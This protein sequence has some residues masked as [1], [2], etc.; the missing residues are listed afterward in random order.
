MIS[1]EAWQ[2]GLVF[3]SEGMGTLR[4]SSRHP[5]IFLGLPRRGG[6]EGRAALR[7]KGL[8]ACS[9][10]GIGE[11][12]TVLRFASPWKM[13]FE[14]ADGILRI[15]FQSSGNPAPGAEPAFRIRFDAPAW[16]HVYGLGPSS[17]FDSAGRK[18]NIGPSR[19]EGSA[20][21][22]PVAF[23]RRGS[24]LAI[25][26]GGELSL[27]FSR[28]HTEIRS[29]SL[30]SELAI[31]EVSTPY[32]G[33]AALTGYRSKTGLGRKDSPVGIGREAG[34]HVRALLGVILS[35]SFAG[36]GC[37]YVPV[38][39]PAN[40][41]R[42]EEERFRFAVEVSAF[43]PIFTS[44]DLGSALR[45]DL[46]ALC[47]RM[48][49]VFDLLAPYRETCM[50][51]WAEEGIPLWS[52]PCIRYGGD[53]E[54]WSLNDELMFG[55]DVLLAPTLEPGDASRRLRLPGGEWIHLW[56]SR[57]YGPGS[58]VVDA[59]AGLPAVFCRTLSVRAISANV[60]SS[61][62]LSTRTSRCSIE[63]CPNA[64]TSSSRSDAGA[65]G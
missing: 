3:S 33:M 45:P 13:D 56:T 30:P 49:K 55:P 61:N 38:E 16:N 7:W 28:K 37:L 29:S 62:T 10:N 23:G 60:I 57:C 64:A 4:H 5:A 17:V 31:R 58:A 43:G 6:G 52:H 2:D 47:R 12:R 24:W 53:E 20:A 36:E 44:R 8:G 65:D 18:V 51:A 42:L 41:S 15:S 22:V 63:S 50:K 40:S 25:G 14:E 46:A 34:F 32:S 26:G 54:L 19:E 9:L 59:P 48:S 21:R 27:D 39:A 1:F 11:G 35:Q